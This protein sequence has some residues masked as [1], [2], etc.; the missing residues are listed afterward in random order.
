[1]VSLVVSKY[2]KTTAWVFLRVN[3]EK[4]PFSFLLK[5]IMSRIFV[6]SYHLSF[7]AYCFFYVHHN[8]TPHHHH[9]NHHRHMHTPKPNHSNKLA[10]VYDGSVKQNEKEKVSKVVKLAS[11]VNESMS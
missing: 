8:P 3:K 6:F 5:P 4:G 1:M 10:C 9:Y 11:Y 2:N 7:Q